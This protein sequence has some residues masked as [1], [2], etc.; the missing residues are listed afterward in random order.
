[1]T[2]ASPL[3]TLTEPATSRPQRKHVL[4]VFISSPGD[5]GAERR[6]TKAVTERVNSSPAA[7]S[8]DMELRPLLWEELPPGQAEPG[9]LQARVNTLLEQYGL[10]RYDI[11]LGMM[12][13]R[14]GTPTPR[15]RSGTVEEFETS[16]ALHRGGGRPEE[17]LFYFIGTD[18]PPEVV[19]LRQELDGEGF[20]YASVA[21][22]EEFEQR[23]E[24]HLLRIVEEWFRWR[25]RLWRL[26]RALM[27]SALVAFL[28]LSM[29]ALGAYV[30]FDRGQFQRIHEVLVQEGALA[31]ARNWG[32]ASAY[33][34]FHGGAMREEINTAMIAE[35]GRHA[36]AGDA[37]AL[38]E[39]W[40]QLPV[41]TP[42]ALESAAAIL[43]ERTSGEIERQLAGPTTT[44]PGRL[45][46]QA[47]RAGIWS[48]AEATSVEVLGSVAGRS[49]FLAL[50]AG[51]GDPFTWAAQLKP[52]ERDALVAF[53]RRVSGDKAWGT[54]AERVAVAA[55]RSDW[56]TL[57]VL[58]TE[59]A[60][61]AGQPAQ[62]RADLAFIQHAPAGEVSKWLRAVVSDQ[63][64]RPVLAGWV[65]AVGL[66]GAQEP[67][68][69]L[70]EL[71][72]DGRLPGELL[73]RSESSESYQGLL[74]TLQAKPGVAAQL[75]RR[76]AEGHTLSVHLLQL[77]LA[78][79]PAS[80]V[81]E[82]AQRLLVMRLIQLVGESP[83]DTDM[84]PE[85]F[86]FLAGTR[87][88]AAWSFLDGKVRDYAEDRISFG[89]AHR[90]ALID[91][92]CGRG[93]NGGAL[94]SLKLALATRAQAAK[95]HSTDKLF[96]FD[97]RPVQTAYL[98]SLDRC[99]M[100]SWERHLSFVDALI[101]SR[102]K[103]AQPQATPL[104]GPFYTALVFREFDAALFSVMAKLREDDL[105]KLLRFPESVFIKGDPTQSRERWWYLLG[106]F[107]RAQRELPPSIFRHTATW[108]PGG[109]V[110]KA[111]HL[112]FLARRGGRLAREHFRG[113]VEKGDWE[114][115]PFL[116][117]EEDTERL[118]K[119]AGRWQPQLEASVLE[120]TMLAA[121][122]L[123]PAR[124]AD[125]VRTL[126]QVLGASRPDI[127]W[128]RAAEARV[129]DSQLVTAAESALQQAQERARVALALRYLG[130]VAPERLHALLAQPVIEARLKQFLEADDAFDW[131]SIAQE[132][133]LPA[134]L[135]YPSW[136]EDAAF[137]RVVLLATSRSKEKD[138]ADER[139]QME[140]QVLQGHLLEHVAASGG[141]ERCKQLLTV[142]EESL[143]VTV[144][145]PLRKE[146][147]WRPYALW[148]AARCFARH[149][150]GVR[151]AIAN[152]SWLTALEGAEPTLQRSVAAAVLT[153]VPARSEP[154][155]R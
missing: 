143:P 24:A 14:L 103:D 58:A 65:D 49:L 105:L 63:V 102:L 37:L 20:L 126:A 127:F 47:Q 68:D 62:P 91:G 26:L 11:Y 33:M 129:L 109:Q 36:Q 153:A 119:D 17:V 123:A 131:M 121:Q 151:D 107:D 13:S 21:N 154:S 48:G 60:G 69:A 149:S 125:I 12:K 80:T 19:Q 112:E 64:A 136:L 59:A 148:L 45:W 135:P 73:A 106:M 100:P 82:A 101:T 31:A 147:A 108:F 61:D 95:Y 18:A 67:A 10:K 40:S 117:L 132:L 130:S 115:L 84:S 92:M 96:G 78:V 27:G 54:P 98:R 38:F 25:R 99:G 8:R 122:R 57:E 128:P 35:F 66:R 9:D 97:D 53:A 51:Q 87:D 39:R 23:I 41:A 72:A 7:A 104:G 56:K 139:F 116:W 2:E 88:A 76:Y 142:S 70:L 79:V 52:V 138:E 28:L 75:L 34:P 85:A 111:K 144:Y 110:T 50:Q 134:S 6:I 74:K 46:L 30:H 120:G 155:A 86:R 90:V 16:R 146:A 44:R 141:V 124:Y 1:M 81:P 137:R 152:A 3:P 55:L 43:R 94:A 22:T 118:A 29:V 140:E 32:E 4:N 77:L 5:C 145:G 89:V 93:G 113:Q 42:R 83:S 15:A 114:A 133:S 150:A 71:A